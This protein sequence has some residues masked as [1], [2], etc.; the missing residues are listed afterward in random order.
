L[1]T[2][3]YVTIKV[4]GGRKDPGQRDVRVKKKKKA[5]WR[6]HTDAI[7]GP[8]PRKWDKR[9]PWGKKGSLNLEKKDSVK[10]YQFQ[11]SRKP[12]VGKTKGGNTRKGGHRLI[13]DRRGNE[14]KLKIDEQTEAKHALDSGLWPS[15]RRLVEHHEKKKK[16]GRVEGGKA[17]E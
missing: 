6:A 4:E 14:N 9:G 12:R 17:L 13:G 11:E 15:D 8:A 1:K 3:W 5:A 7:T 16:N 2:K 10:N